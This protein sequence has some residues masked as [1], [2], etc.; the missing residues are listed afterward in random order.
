MAAEEPGL[1]RHEWESEWASLEEDI[2]DA[3][4]VALPYLHDLIGRMLAERRVLDRS[5]VAVQGADPELLRPWQAGG[6][7]VRRLADGVDVEHD[8]VVEQIEN[9]RLL[10]EALL[11]GRAPP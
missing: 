2:A 5:R 1:D 4:R 6:E 10:F 7:L 3:P 8:D 11:A 9:Y